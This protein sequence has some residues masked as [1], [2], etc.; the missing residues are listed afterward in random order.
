MENL[1]EYLERKWNA[2]IY[3]QAYGDCDPNDCEIKGK[4]DFINDLVK[5]IE[6]WYKKVGE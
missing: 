5:Y 4:E 1:R 3:I 2:E 6:T